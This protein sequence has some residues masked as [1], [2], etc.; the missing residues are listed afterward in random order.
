[1]D[2][3]DSI[4]RSDFLAGKGKDSEES[5]EKRLLGGFTN[6]FKLQYQPLGFSWMIFVDR[7]NFDRQHYDFRYVRREFLGD[8]RCL[9]LDITPKKDA[10]HG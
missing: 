1:M 3:S 10:G 5:M 8:V 4:D 2:L 7:D 9:V 6:L